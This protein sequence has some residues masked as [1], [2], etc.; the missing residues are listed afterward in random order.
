MAWH[1]PLCESIK[2]N[3]S[4]HVVAACLL[5]A[6]AVSS[7]ILVHF[8]MGRDVFAWHLF[9]SVSCTIAVCFTIVVRDTRP[10]PPL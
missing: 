5:M 10:S 6:M 8:F 3:K 7:F 1:G 2:S 4:M 9:C